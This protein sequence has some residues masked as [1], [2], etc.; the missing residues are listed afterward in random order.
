MLDVRLACRWR[1]V[2]LDVRLEGRDLLLFKMS[3]YVVLLEML[4]G[5]SL[6]D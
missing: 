1:L 3:L 2:L 4:D 6:C 5:S